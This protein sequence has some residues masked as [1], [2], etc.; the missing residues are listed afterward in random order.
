MSWGFSEG[1]PTPSAPPCAPSPLSLSPP[2]GQPRSGHLSPVPPAWRWGC[3]GV[4][5]P[6]PLVEVPP[7]E[8]GSPGPSGTS[9]LSLRVPKRQPGHGAGTP[10]RTPDV[11]PARGVPAGCGNN[12]ISFEDD[13]TLGAEGTA[14]PRVSPAAVSP[15]PH[16]QRQGGRSRHPWF[17]WGWDVP[18]LCVPSGCDNPGGTS[19]PNPSPCHSCP[20]S[21]PFSQPFCYWG[22]TR[23]RAG[24]LWGAGGFGDIVPL[25]HPRPPLSQISK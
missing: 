25:A 2:P 12:G 13:L 10:P 4:V 24:E 14:R 18:R 3:N 20:L 8:P 19:V 23:P 7:E 1:T 9:A 15:S 17:W 5:P 16:G 11:S 22:P 6:R 21:A